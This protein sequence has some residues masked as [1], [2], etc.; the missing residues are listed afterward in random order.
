MLII[1][2]IIAVWILFLLLIRKLK[3]YFFVFVV[4]SIGLF[5]ILMY[6][7]RGTVE[8]YL[9]HAVTYSMYLISKAT[10]IYVAHPEYSML[11]VYYNSQAVSFFVD[12]ECSGFIESIV[13]LSLLT[14]YPI[15]RWKRKIFLGIAGTL[16]IF[17]SNIIRVF[18]ICVII[19]KFGPSLFFFSHTV[20]ARVLFFF[21]MV[22]LYYVVFTMAHILRQKVGRIG[23]E[24]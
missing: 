12:Y 20:F 3:I 19:K 9:E 17:I 24:N 21:L 1:L 16:Y 7:G 15:Y 11:T 14:F 13:Y 4:G 22:G 5:C 8:K 2:L 10:D 18:I 6:I 23:Y